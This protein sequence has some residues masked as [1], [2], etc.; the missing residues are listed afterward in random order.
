MSSQVRVEIMTPIATVSIDGSGGDRLLDRGAWRTLADAFDELS[1][2]SD[3][4]CIVVCGAG[5]RSAPTGSGPTPSPEGDQERPS[6]GEIARALLAVRAC[7]HPTVAVIEGNCSGEGLEIAASCDLRV[8][9]ESSRFGAP[10]QGS[11]FIG[12]REEVEPIVQILGASPVVGAL[13]RGE[14][15]D[16]DRASTC[17]LVNRIYSDRSVRARGYGLAARIAAGAPLVNRWHKKLLR[18]LRERPRRVEGSESD[19]ARAFEA[20]AHR[21]GCGPTGRRRER[22]FGGH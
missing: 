18:R 3:V 19:E 13:R 5:G 17:G 4:T 21:E 20:E 6:R 22:R 11:T 12:S 14:L 15:I 10:I 16:A 2:R 8:C 1:L 7:A 9:G